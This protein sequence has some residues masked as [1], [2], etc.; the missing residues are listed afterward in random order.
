MILCMEDM[1]KIADA[2]FPLAIRG[3]F[4]SIFIFFQTKRGTGRLKERARER[5]TEGP[6]SKDLPGVFLSPQEMIYS[7]TITV[8][9]PLFILFSR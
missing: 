8:L 5:E 3:T 6:N 1:K 4:L 7:I 9:T 2:K